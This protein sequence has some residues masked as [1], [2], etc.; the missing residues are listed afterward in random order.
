MRKLDVW[1]G[2]HKG[3]TLYLDLDQRADDIVALLVRDAAGAQKACLLYIGKEGIERASH[4]PA[5]LGF[6]TT[7]GGRIALHKEDPVI[8]ELANLKEDRGRRRCEHC[9][10]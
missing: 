1:D 8:K 10:Y 5:P 7:V 9:G 3:P 2:L 6:A 4:T